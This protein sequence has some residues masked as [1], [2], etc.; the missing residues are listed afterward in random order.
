MRYIK[1]YA[2]YAKLSLMSKLVYKVNAI[3]GILAFLFMEATSL[4]TLYILVSSV[5]SIDGYDIY[6]IG[7]LFG[8]TNLAVGLDHLFTDRLW[9]VAYFEVKQGKLDH[10]FLRPVPVLFQVIASEIQ[11]EALG[12]L[13]V[14]VAMI[15][16]CGSKVQISGGVGPILL[17]LLG[18]I[19]AA[20]II[21]SFKI[22]V[23]S[24]AFKFKRSGPLLQFIYNFSGF[25]KY[26]MNIY[27]KAIRIILTFV[28]PL[29]LC[30]FYPFDNL[31][32]PIESPHFVALMMVGFTT[33]F[34]A[35]CLFV[36]S[37]LV[38]M[39]ESTGT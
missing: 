34:G 8:I 14:A 37:K 23:A 13:I 30:L 7:M 33:I 39:Y 18:V 5:P 1:L 29:G 20:L 10:M 3:I 24:L 21:T 32:R 11:L 6:Q 16:F 4:I 28:I 36:W 35:I 12:E 25:T 26:P 27:P 19:C 22:M 17:V 38:K 9:S 31:F 15:S 2:T